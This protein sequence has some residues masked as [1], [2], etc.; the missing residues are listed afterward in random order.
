M[1]KIFNCIILSFIVVVLST[2]QDK[3]CRS[4]IDAGLGFNKLSYDAYKSTK[5]APDEDL[6]V[7]V[8]LKL[9]YDYSIN[10]R[11]SAGGI[12]SG[13]QTVFFT[14]LPEGIGESHYDYCI[15]GSVLYHYN[16]FENADIYSGIR[17]G[18]RYTKDETHLPVEDPPDDIKH[19]PSGQLVLFGLRLFDI[20][21]LG[22]N[23]EVVNIGSPCTIY[24]GLAY[25]F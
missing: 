4:H 15:M 9:G 3:I 5:D 25:R 22:I 20:G 12:F 21:G 2:A 17:A 8:V 13:Q 23:V 14:N 6:N 10:E 7:A 16:I 1:K 24:F 18:Y 11:I 19:R